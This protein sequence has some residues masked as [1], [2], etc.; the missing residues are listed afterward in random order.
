MLPSHPSLRLWQDSH[1]RLLRGEPEGAPRLAYTS[2]VRF[3]AGT[4]LTH[5]DEPR[6]LRTA[7][8]LGNGS[9]TEITFRRLTATE[10][11]LAW[12][13]H[14]FLLDVEDRDLIST[15]FDQIAT[16][17]NHL[18]CYDLD[19]PRLYDDLDRLLEAVAA[20]ATSERTL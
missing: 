11:L 5:C 10:T 15:H 4:R 17:A 7:Y 9:A 20:H 3:I 19:Y 12:A 16:L 1:E 6:P 8:F 14:S 13:K 2:K 18:A